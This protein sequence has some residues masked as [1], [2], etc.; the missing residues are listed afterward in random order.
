MPKLLF[1]LYLSIVLI[2]SFLFIQKA[3]PQTDEGNHLLTITEI[4]GGKINPETFR[5]N[6]QIPG[7]YLFMAV[8]KKIIPGSSLNSLRLIQTIF[9]ILAIWI[10]YQIILLID[11]QNSQL[12]T[13]KILSLPVLNI[14]WVLLYNDAFSLLF[15]MLSFYCLLK[16]HFPLSWLFALFSLFIR[17]N[18]IVW[19][20]F[21]IFYHFWQN[22][23][24]P[25]KRK[26]AA[27][28][29][30]EVS[31][32]ACSFIF[33]LIF[34]FVNK[35]PA[36]ADKSA[37]PF[38]LHV[39]NIYFVLL[40]SAILFWPGIIFS[41]KKVLK[42]VRQ[43]PWFWGLAVL[44]FMVYLFLFKA[45][46]W[47]NNELFNFWL[48]NKILHHMLSTPFL[49]IAYFIP[50]LL[51]LFWFCT[52]VFIKKAQYVL[53]PFSFLFL[54]LSWLVE[55]R[56]YIVPLVFFLIFTR[57]QKPIVEKVQILWFIIMDVVLLFGAVN[58]LYFL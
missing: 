13:V 47:F 56:Y 38:S 22:Y 28:F 51:S 24:L 11:P 44:S 49:K 9:S 35:G 14:F 1:L 12:K 52:S 42:K 54:A 25:L 18:N 33:I 4:S 48:R 16:K 8:F 30:K 53:Y 40:T 10:I 17:Q 34:L 7:Y 46:N 23:N 2:I 19:I 6:A 27:K 15:L 29:L 39:E 55:P 26:S 43:N 45:D 50:I 37:N 3:A 32:F 31:G 36:L 20:T 5:R 57:T 41:F 21:F 58:Q